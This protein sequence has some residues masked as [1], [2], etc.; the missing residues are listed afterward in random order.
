VAINPKVLMVWYLKAED[1]LLGDGY[2]E[3]ETGEYSSDLSYREC[4][5]GWK[6]HWI[7]SNER[8][9]TLLIKELVR[10]N[11]GKYFYNVKD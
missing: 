1:I 10:V 5:G 3:E 7:V 8:I 9:L 6:C 2:L 11:K 4:G